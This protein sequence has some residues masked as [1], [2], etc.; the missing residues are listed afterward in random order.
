MVDTTQPITDGQWLDQARPWIYIKEYG[1]HLKATESHCRILGRMT[2]LVFA[3]YRVIIAA[4]GLEVIGMLLKRIHQGRN[5][6]GRNN[7]TCDG[8]PVRAGQESVRASWIFG[9]GYWVCR[10]SYR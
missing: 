8:L 5:W 6:G 4:M 3:F 2:V 7:R 9:L 10:G 1:L